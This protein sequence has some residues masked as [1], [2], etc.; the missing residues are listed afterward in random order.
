MSIL[1]IVGPF[2]M[3]LGGVMLAGLLLDIL[4]DFDEHRA[5]FRLAIIVP[6]ALVVWWWLS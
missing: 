5:L 2:C 6:C 4:S 3:G 1:D